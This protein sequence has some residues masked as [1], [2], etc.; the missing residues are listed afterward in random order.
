MKQWRDVLGESLS[1][2]LNFGVIPGVALIQ[3]LKADPQIKHDIS[4]LIYSFNLK[5]AKQ[6]TPKWGFIE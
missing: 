3:S 4:L 5:M 6:N 1:G 2:G